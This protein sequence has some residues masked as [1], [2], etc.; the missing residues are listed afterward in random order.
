MLSV[1]EAKQISNTGVKMLDK[2]FNDYAII[3]KNPYF[4]ES[5]VKN[6]FKKEIIAIIE[7]ERLTAATLAIDKFYT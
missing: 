1:Q 2:V 4:T 7:C 5:Q 6:E 3:I